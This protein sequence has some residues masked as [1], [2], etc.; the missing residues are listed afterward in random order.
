MYK[1]IRG[2]AIAL[3]FFVFYSVSHAQLTGGLN[4]PFESVARTNSAS[5]IALNPAGLGFNQGRNFN[6]A[7]SHLSDKF[8]SDT[9]IYFAFGNVGYSLE[10]LGDA[11]PRRK[12]SF[13]LA[14]GDGSNH[15][16][17]FGYSRFG[18]DDVGYSALNMLT[19]GL[20]FRPAKWLSLAGVATDVR[21]SST[22]VSIGSGIG[23]LESR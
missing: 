3:T 18:S 14:L 6:I 5:S 12:H 20:D 9:G 1:F 11:T 19:A 10:W 2:S 17:G 21:G 22:V 4:L 16:I 8:F 13:A 7:Q 23:L 15:S